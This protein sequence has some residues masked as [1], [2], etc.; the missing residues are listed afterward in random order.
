VDRRR[1]P[2]RI[3]ISG[4][5]SEEG[6]R[7]EESH[8]SA[9]P[10]LFRYDCLPI[11]QG[12]EMALPRQD[13]VMAHLKATLPFIVVLAAGLALIYYPEGARWAEFVRA[14]RDALMVAGIIG[15]IIETWAAAVLID[16]VATRISERLVGYGLP[17]S[18]R[19]KIQSIVHETKIICQDYRAVYRIS[20]D[21][22]RAGRIR[23]NITMSY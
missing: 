8:I 5:S 11:K 4:C 16:H 6:E 22:T 15:I 3:F 9:T 2:L 1:G 12:D 20:L 14:L 18:A 23:L 10:F 21:P 19:E 13:A 17:D 7:E